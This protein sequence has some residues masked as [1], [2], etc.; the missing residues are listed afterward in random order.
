[1]NTKESESSLPL[2][3]IIMPVYNTAAFLPMALDS[4]IAQTYSS[5]EAILVDDGST[6]GSGEIC[7]SYAARDPR[8]RVIH[9]SNA[10]V[11][12]ARNAGLDAARGEYIGFVDSDDWADPGMFATL[13][14]DMERNDADV[15]KCGFRTVEK[16]RTHE[17]SSGS[18]R[19]I[20]GGHA[21]RL[22][23]ENKKIRS[24]LWDKLYRRS[25]FNVRFPEGRIYED[26]CVL[27]WVLANARK[28]TLNPTPLY[29]YRQRGDSIVHT[30]TIDNK[31]QLTDAVADRYRQVMNMKVGGWSA[32]DK[33]KVYILEILKVCCAIVR[34]FPHTPEADS[35][36][37]ELRG[38]L[39]DTSPGDITV[40]GP[41]YMLWFTTL[42]ISP[43][44]FRG[45][46][47]ATSIKRKK[48][49]TF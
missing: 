41:K 27:L 12:A 49:K 28:V 44:F 32:R 30:G 11:S 43:A 31:R 40:L 18:L 39:R 48:E 35:F 8:F 14:A 13:V 33:K 42:K 26:M 9:K 36:L 21:A 34:Y 24:F 16:D 10:G 15:A 6:D 17:P 45:T 20:D 38:R 2:V 37:D 22:L 29:N 3:S 5:W 1:M 7:D 25:I 19:V 4:I 47:N 46:L 23:Y